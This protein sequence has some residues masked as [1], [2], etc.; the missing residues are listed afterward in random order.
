MNV[1]SVLENWSDVD[2]DVSGA[3][4]EFSG[5]SDS[6]EQEEVDSSGEDE[7]CESWKEI[8]GKFISY[9][10]YNSVG[11]CTLLYITHSN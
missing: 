11:R 6:S 10:K 8:P 2:S 3:S 1:D 4:L 7:V 5:D 9:K